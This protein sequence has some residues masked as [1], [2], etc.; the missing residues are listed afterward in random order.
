VTRIAPIIATVALAIVLRKTTHQ[1]DK[2]VNPP[3]PTSARQCR[4]STEVPQ[5]EGQ[6]SG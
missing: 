1:T 5:F 4:P 2:A 3:W 6:P